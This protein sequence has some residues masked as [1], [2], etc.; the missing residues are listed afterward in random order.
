MCVFQHELPVLSV[1]VNLRE[2]FVNLTVNI[3]I[4]LKVNAHIFANVSAATKIVNKSTK[5]VNF[6]FFLYSLRLVIYKT[7]LSFSSQCKVSVYCLSTI[8]LFIV[9]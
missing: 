9:V 1:N 7:N 4:I 3:N 8:F 6:T 2:S 5:V